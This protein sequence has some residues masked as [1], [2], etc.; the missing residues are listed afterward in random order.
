MISLQTS[1]V[2]LTPLSDADEDLFVELYTSARLMSKIADTFSK[3]RAQKA[4]IKTLQLTLKPRPTI[5]SWVVQD[6]CTNRSLGIVGFSAIDYPHQADIGI[7]LKREA[8]GK[9]IVVDLCNVLCEYLL[10]QVAISRV[11]AEFHRENLATHKITRIMGFTTAMPH[12]CK[13]DTLECFLTAS[14]FA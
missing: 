13:A 5:M 7:I 4:F 6:K 11:R 12:K 1:K 2:W 9:G 3:A 8:H 10:N 14:K